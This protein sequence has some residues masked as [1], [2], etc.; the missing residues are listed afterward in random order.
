MRHQQ[1]QQVHE[2]LTLFGIQWGEDLLLHPQ[3]DRNALAQG[4]LAREGERE[5]AHAPV[6]GVG[7][8]LQPAAHLQPI[9]HAAGGRSIER[10]V[11]RQAA[12]VNAGLVAHGLQHR[13]LHRRDADFCGFL[14]KDTH[15]NLLQP[16]NDVAGLLVEL[17]VGEGIGI[18]GREAYG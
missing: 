10:N 11:T 18:H 7:A 17:D 15:R 16:T 9:H 6:V 13:V 3:H 2:G 12:L 5:F 4:L 8:A 14:Q 1:V